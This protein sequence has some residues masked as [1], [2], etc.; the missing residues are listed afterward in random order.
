MKNFKKN[1]DKAKQLLLKT[2]EK[3]KDIDWTSTIESNRV[4]FR[5]NIILL[6]FNLKYSIMY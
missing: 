1:A 3:M 5:V 2:I 4:R 6:T